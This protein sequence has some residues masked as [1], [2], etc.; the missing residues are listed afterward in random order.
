MTLCVIEKNA[1][2][3][4][5]EPLSADTAR[6]RLAD[7][8]RCVA[9]RDVVGKIVDQLWL[10]QKPRHLDWIGCEVAPLASSALFY[11]AWV[12][13]AQR[14]RNVHWAMASQACAQALAMGFTKISAGLDRHEYQPFAHKYAEMGLA[15]ITPY[16]SL[17]C[18]PATGWNVTCNPPRIL[19]DLSKGLVCA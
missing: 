1:G 8:D 17:W 6:L 3:F 14:G 12:D 13:P 9:V 18:M 10:T 16:A 2:L 5:G 4:S 19:V 7:G 11:N 15:I